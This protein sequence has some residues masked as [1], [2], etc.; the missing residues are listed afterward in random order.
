V[1]VGSSAF[2]QLTADL[3]HFRKTPVFVKSV[4]TAV[5]IATAFGK[6]RS[7]QPH[8]ISLQLIWIRLCPIFLVSNVTGEGL[9]FV[10][11]IFRLSRFYSTS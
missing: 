9:D 1:Q 8:P 7:V 4:E 5:E 3:S 6:D 10:S 2:D 11:N